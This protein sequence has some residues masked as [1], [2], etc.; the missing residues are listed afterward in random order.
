MKNMGDFL[1]EYL[2]QFCASIF[3]HLHEME[4]FLGKYG[5]EIDSS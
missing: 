1:K 5:I 2:I 4:I 3:E